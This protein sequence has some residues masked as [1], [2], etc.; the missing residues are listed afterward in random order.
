MIIYSRLL[1][2]PSM[3]ILYSSIKSKDGTVTTSSLFKQYPLRD[4]LRLYRVQIVIS[5]VKSDLVGMI[6]ALFAI[7]I[8]F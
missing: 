4:P 3:V 6:L 1:I 8:F 2:S 5:V 7:S